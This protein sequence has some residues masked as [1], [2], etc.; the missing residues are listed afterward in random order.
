MM[1]KKKFTKMIAKG[2]ITLT[3]AS[4]ISWYIINQSLKIENKPKS[5]DNNERILLEERIRFESKNELKNKLVKKKYNIDCQ[6]IF[7][8]NDTLAIHQAKSLS[9]QIKKSKKSV[10]N[11]KSDENFIFDRSTCEDYKLFRDFNQ[12]DKYNEEIEIN[13]PLAYAILV[14]K[15]AEQIDR[16]LRLIWR[17]QNI[18]CFH[19]DSNSNYLFKQAIKSIANCFDNVF[20]TKN[21]QSIV[22]GSFS[23]LKAELNCMNDLIKSNISWKYLIHMSGDEFPLKTNYELVKILS[24]YMGVNDLDINFGLS[25][26]H[27][28]EH[29]YLV[30]GNKVIKTKKMKKKP[31]HGYKIMKGHTTSVLSREFSEYIL[32]DQKVNDLIEWAKDTKVPDEM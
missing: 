20:I 16:L 8:R 18:Y 24:L 10:N 2:L 3:L 1:Q 19:I 28:I 12:I 31:P 26:L 6:S 15:N 21:S 4:I 23:I 17:P 22:R 32:T 29:S 5:L 14:Y 7:L 27:R 11:H 9:D 13:F 25:Y 30:K